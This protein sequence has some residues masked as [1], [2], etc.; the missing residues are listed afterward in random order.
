MVTIMVC[1][2]SL[3]RNTRLGIIIYTVAMETIIGSMPSPTYICVCI[4]FTALQVYN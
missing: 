1:A 3:L 4:C 2:A